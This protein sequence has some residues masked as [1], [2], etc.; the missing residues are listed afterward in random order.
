MTAFWDTASRI[1]AEVYTDV[2]EV[3]IAGDGGSTHL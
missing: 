3:R 1:L 2:S